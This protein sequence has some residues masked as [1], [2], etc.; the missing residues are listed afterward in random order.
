MVARD[1]RMSRVW[2]RAARRG[3]PPNATT[4]S[5]ST[6]SRSSRAAPTTTALPRAARSRPSVARARCRRG[7][8]A[9]AAGPRVVREL[10]VRLFQRLRPHRRAGRSRRRAASRRL[11]LRVPQRHYGNR[12]D[13][14]GRPLGRVPFPDRELLHAR[15]LPRALRAVPRGS[16]PAGGASP[17]SVHRHLGRSRDSP[18]MPGAAAPGITTPAR[19]TG[20]RARRRRVA[21]GAS[22]C[23]CANRR[24]PTSGMYRQ[25][26]FGDLADLLMLDTRSTVATCKRAR[27]RRRR[28]RTRL[29]AAARRAQEEWLFENLRDS[30]PPASRGRFSGSR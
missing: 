13:G 20:P 11:H 9:G 3:P 10:S 21:P 1:A 19:A 24:R 14:D 15:R 6:R 12:P 28:G 5:R 16:G 4:R 17:A 23:R 7:R 30:V 25:F 18:T 29:A 22:G 26:T 2:S 27:E 8:R